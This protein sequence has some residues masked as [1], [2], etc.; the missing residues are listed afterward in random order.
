MEQ[1]RRTHPHTLYSPGGH[2]TSVPVE[3]PEKAVHAMNESCRTLG[4]NQV[5]PE[6]SEPGMV[7]VKTQRLDTSPIQREVSLPAKWI[8]I[9]IICTGLA[10]GAFVWHQYGTSANTVWSA[11]SGTKDALSDRNNDVGCSVGSLMPRGNVYRTSCTTSLVPGALEVSKALNC[12][13][14]PVSIVFLQVVSM[15]F[16]KQT[17]HVAGPVLTS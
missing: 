10:C 11:P 1:Q 13:A 12:V 16:L 3:I 8:A 9:A 7:H 4:C 6:C 5:S 14:P 15:S 17:T 2:L